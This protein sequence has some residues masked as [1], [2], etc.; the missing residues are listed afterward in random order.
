MKRL[1]FLAIA[2]ILA[3]TAV[4]QMQPTAEPVYPVMPT[5]PALRTGKLANGMRYYIRHNDKQKNLADFHIIHNVGAIQ[6]A[7]NQQGLAHFLEHMAFNGTINLPGKTLI[8]Y[9]EKVGVKFGANLNAGTSWD[10]T[11]YMMK[12]V[13]VVRQGVIDTA[14][15]VLHDWS[16]FIEL[17]PEE[18]DS[19]R[20][21][22]MEE[23]RT[24]DGA[25]WRSTIKLI[26]AVAKGTLYEHRNLIGHL[27]GLKSFSYD[28]IRTFY[29]KWYRPDYQAVV[30]VGDI[31]VDKVE[32]QIKSLMSD[33]PAPAP[34]A[35][36][37]DVIVVP[38]NVEPIISIFEDPEMIESEASIF[39]KREAMPLKMRNTIVA[40]Q[41]ALIHSLGAQMANTR[42]AE[43]A[44][45]PNAPFIRA[46]IHNGGI[47]ICPTLDMLTCGVTTKDG[48]LNE[49][50]EAAYTELERIRRHGFTE[51]EF[52]RAKQSVLRREEQAYTNRN[53]RKN[54]EYVR[55][56]T[57]NFRKNTAMPD[58]EVEWKTDSV[59]I[60]QLPLAAVNQ[61]FAQYIT[62]HNNVIVVNAPKKEGVVNPSESDILATIAKVKGSEIAPY[63]DNTIKEPLIADLK[64]LKGSPVKK[65][66]TTT[67][68]MLGTTEWTL[69][70]GVKVV[71]R[72]SVFKADE[73][74]VDII[75]N[76]HG[77]ANLSDEDCNTANLF[78]MIMGNQGVS[79][80][81]VSDLRK[82]LSGKAASVQIGLGDYKTSIEGFGSPK[83]LETLM[84]LLY[85][86]FT[87]PRFNE[88]DFNVTIGQLRSYV[89]NLKS[90]P[91]YVASAEVQKTLYGNSP[92]RQQI[93]TEMLNNV[94]FERLASIH[95]QLFS[96]IADF[97]VYITGNV[98]LESLKPLVEKYIGSI[99]ASKRLTPAKD[100]GVRYVKGV[101]VNDFRVAMQQPKVGVYRFYTGEIP[102]TL[103]N[104][105]AMSFLSSALT[106]RYTIS[107]REE[108][109]GTYGVGVGGRVS[110]KFEPKYILQVQFDTNEQMA[111]ELSDIVVA[112]L[113][114]IANEGP[115]AAD[116]DKTREYLLKEWQ[117]QLR[118]NGSWAQ[119]IMEKYNNGLDYIGSYEQ[120]VKDM[121]VEKVQALAK[122]ILSDN[123]MTYVVM[124][125]QK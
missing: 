87:Q 72:P 62:D 103:E 24:R 45:K 123:N 21:V 32:A 80:F 52:E 69:K 92:R 115:L 63:A 60:S 104:K 109:G 108:K 40:E 101:V 17:K 75:S 105:V 78:S 99:P 97:T 54:A 121:S 64:A 13:P 2:S 91:D 23:L 25:D 6:E 7:D 65:S 11:E 33:I 95:K 15:L 39:I 3:V 8:E 94:K 50:L 28:D 49:G 37:K 79:K 111:D 70:N 85:L 106:S 4:A 107:I 66:K 31:D 26:K 116:V 67:D 16:H 10:Y 119:F 58:A 29:D 88:D 118:D 59:I 82:L 38:D 98:D 93:S 73:V 122:K 120:I 53:D 1:F 9:L 124:R 55:R 42:L 77:I 51:S 114:K 96:N 19:E 36:E 68:Q 41:F 48:G 100:D 89:E 27:E 5:D 22:I 20:G 86:N 18:I 90:N 61:V 14:M 34:D 83:D 43:M 56:Y 76:H 30:I 47:G 44:M 84:Q 74:C 12:D 117:N 125:P 46:Y 113:Q 102:Y 110:D 71:V 112:E 35:P 81:S 57:S